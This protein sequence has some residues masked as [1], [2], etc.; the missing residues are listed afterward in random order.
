MK[1]KHVLRALFLL[2]YLL[3]LLHVGAETFYWYWTFPWF[4]LLTH[5]LGGVCV[6]LGTL[7][8][9]FMSGYIKQHQRSWSGRLGLLYTLIGVGVIGVG[10]ELYEVFVHL[11][12]HTPFDRG[13]LFDTAGDLTMD[14]LGALVSYLCFAWKA[15]RKGV[16]EQRL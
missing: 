3:F 2:I 12:L 4:D 11:A 1:T 16:G 14:T 6:G 7:W 13:Y 9:F 5:F 15:K 10:W 8:F